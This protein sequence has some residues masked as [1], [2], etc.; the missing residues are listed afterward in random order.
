MGLSQSYLVVN[1]ITLFLSLTSPIAVL[2]KLSEQYLLTAA[3]YR[4]FAVAK[5][6]NIATQ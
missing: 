6:T 2:C 5:T 3:E 1:Y 4:I